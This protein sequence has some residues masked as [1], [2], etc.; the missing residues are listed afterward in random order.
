MTVATGRSVLKEAIAM[1]DTP[2]IV[3]NGA[4]TAIHGVPA[5]TT[6]LDWLREHV[7]LRGTK[8][9]C[10]EGDCGA[11]TVVVERL[12]ETGAIRSEAINSCLAMV[13]QFDGVGVRTVEGLAA[14]DGTLH[15]V[16]AA[17]VETGGTQCGF[18]TP[19]FIMAAYAFAAGGEPPRPDLI[20]D[21]IAGNLCRCTGY[22]PIVDAIARA[23]LDRDPID[24]APDAAAALQQVARPSAACFDVAG[25]QF[26]VPRSLAEAAALRARWPQ[27]L[28][29]AGGTDLGLLASR[30][31]ERLPQIIHLGKVPELNAIGA[32]GDALLIGAGATY[33]RAFDALTAWFPTIRTYLTRL[34]SR[35]IR[36]M[37]TIGGNL[38]T[39]SP[40]GDMPPILLAADARILCHSAA[41]GRREIAADEFFV[42]YRKTVLAP[43][44]LIEAV[45]IPRPAADMVFFVDKI[46]KRRDQDISS[47]C[48]AYRL[49]LAN[50]VVGDVRLAFGG[51]AATPKRATRA[52]RALAG[53]VLD[54]AAID[55]AVHA[56]REDFQPIG[57]WRASAEYRSAVT[58]N[59]L[60]RLHLRVTAPEVP[61]EI[62]A[63]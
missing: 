40:I 37:G 14:A 55:A 4:P 8:E 23:A 10:A 49:E 12:D 56:L 30:Q 48:G 5:A 54:E 34:G 17:F 16:Q 3:L 31:R 26:H 39:A 27:A 2:T 15:P 25:Q 44:E 53:G 18:C 57:D 46:S 22:R 41:R 9:G 45:V 59:L 24:D 13:G 29:L 1:S 60:R 7:Q 33:T 43:D 28:L 63:L 51:L 6:L 32:R 58:A 21:A 50:G 52:E 47:V 61:L 19:G 62:D 42:G 35:Q 11:C 36:N 20:H 38:G